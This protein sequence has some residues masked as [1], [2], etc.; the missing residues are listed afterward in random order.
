M[1]AEIPPVLVMVTFKVVEHPNASVAVTKYGPAA[2]PEAV[3]PVCM[4]D[5]FQE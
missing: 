2:N 3:A 5:V 1:D 4:G